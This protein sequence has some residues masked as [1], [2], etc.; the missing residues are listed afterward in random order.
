MGGDVHLAA[1]TRRHACVHACPPNERLR[2]FAQILCAALRRA[3]ALT[4]PL[5]PCAPQ[6]VAHEVLALELLVLMLENPSDDSVEVAVDFCKDVGAYL[7]VR[8]LWGA[9]GP[10][11]VR[12]HLVVRWPPSAAAESRRAPPSPAC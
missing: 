5:P 4:C 6:G 12:S 8:A 2:R 11:R 7:Q 3:Q 10:S 1:C 9:P